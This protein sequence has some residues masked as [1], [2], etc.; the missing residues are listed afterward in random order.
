MKSAEKDKAVLASV[1]ELIDE[2]LI[3]KE[4]TW[5]GYHGRQKQI[6]PKKKHYFK[7]HE[8]VFD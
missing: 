8:E 5:S 2:E 6:R 7:I 3:G 1:D 4:D